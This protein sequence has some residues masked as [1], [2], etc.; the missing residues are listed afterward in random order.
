MVGGAYTSGP[1]SWG[2]T[3]LCVVHGRQDGAAVFGVEAGREVEMTSYRTID[4]R[5]AHWFPG[6]LA[7]G[8]GPHHLFNK[9]NH[10]L[11]RRQVRRKVSH[12]CKTGVCNPQATDQYQS[13]A[14]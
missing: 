1:R 6:K 13:A 7:A 2:N 12:V 10:Q 5:W 11:G 4:V 9:N 8:H 14:C 3:S